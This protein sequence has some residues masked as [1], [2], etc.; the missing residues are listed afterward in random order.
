[1]VGGGAEG[2][3]TRFKQATEMSLARDCD[4]FQNRIYPQLRKSNGLTWVP[5]CVS[6]QVICDR[7]G[8]VEIRLAFAK[9]DG[10]LA[11]EIAA[12]TELRVLYVF[13]KF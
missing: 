5:C 12:L 10:S 7:A 3:F 11:P 9:L 8:I 6:P 1:M 2:H 4:L 13:F